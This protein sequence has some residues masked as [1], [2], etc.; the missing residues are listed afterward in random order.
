M[1][2]SDSQH[3]LHSFASDEKLEKEQLDLL[4]Q[5]DPS[6]GENDE[7]ST[8]APLDEASISLMY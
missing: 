4:K 2:K 3:S 8:P 1:K 6:Q 5:G 7:H